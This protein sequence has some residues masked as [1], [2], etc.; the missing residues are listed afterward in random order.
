[1]SGP[2]L[3]R[4]ENDFKDSKALSSSLSA[5]SSYDLSRSISISSI[6]KNSDQILIEDIKKLKNKQS[7]KSNFII[8]SIF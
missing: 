1:V 5:M 2:E 3:R 6:S 4:K 8:I 7:N